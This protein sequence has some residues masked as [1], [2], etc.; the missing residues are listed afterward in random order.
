MNL[1]PQLH[2][3]WKVCNGHKKEVI[4]PKELPIFQINKK[5]VP[6]EKHDSFLWRCLCCH[7][8]LLT[9]LLV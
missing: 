4:K 8:A 9:I 7:F 5:L 3:F 6:Y 2:H 1:S